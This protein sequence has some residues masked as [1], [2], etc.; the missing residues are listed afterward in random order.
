MESHESIRFTL[1]F[2]TYILSNQREKISCGKFGN[3]LTEKKEALNGI[4]KNYSKK[5]IQFHWIPMSS[6]ECFFD[7]DWIHSVAQG[8]N[9]ELT[10]HSCFPPRILWSR[11][12][13]QIGIKIMSLCSVHAM[14][15]D[16]N[17]IWQSV[18]VFWILEVMRVHGF[19]PSYPTYGNGV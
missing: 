11:K 4:L 15:N 12:M 17:D 8:K 16:V 14:S 10:W 3:S 1:H 13:N 18:F 2:L 19:G 6:Y 7:Y 5:F 9:S